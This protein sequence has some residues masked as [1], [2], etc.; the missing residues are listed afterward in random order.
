MGEEFF[1]W[2]SDLDS[3]LYQVSHIV[4]CPSHW[5][6]PHTFSII[7]RGHT[8]KWSLQ[9]C[10]RAHIVFCLS[11]LSVRWTLWAW[12]LWKTLCLSGWL[13][14][15][16][17]HFGPTSTNTSP[18]IQMFLLSCFIS[19]WF[20]Q[21]LTPLCED[22]DVEPQMNSRCV[23]CVNDVA[24]GKAMPQMSLVGVSCTVGFLFC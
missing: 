17:I 11:Y 2:F 23:R 20:N 7:S 10:I 1:N 19:L 21:S 5:F 9:G 13:I 3:I 12:I 15:C 24:W 4:W 6:Q 8:H 18:H 22:L 14:S 16:P